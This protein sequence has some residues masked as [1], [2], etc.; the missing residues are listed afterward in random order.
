MLLVAVEAAD[1]FVQ[2][3]LGVLFGLG[4]EWVVDRTGPTLFFKGGE[5]RLLVA[6]GETELLDQLLA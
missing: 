5:D 1:C 6:R 3:A 4:W 2:A